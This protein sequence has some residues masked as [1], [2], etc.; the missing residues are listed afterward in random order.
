MAPHS[1]A[2]ANA[3]P[4]PGPAGPR[5]TDASAVTGIPAVGGLDLRKPAAAPAP[6]GG[7]VGES[8]VSSEESGVPLKKR[9]MLVL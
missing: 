2:N 4:G 5:L 1:S 6:A 7:G 3:G 8:P 9:K